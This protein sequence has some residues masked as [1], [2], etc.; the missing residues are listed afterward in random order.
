V[1]SIKRKVWLGLSLMILGYSISMIFGFFYGQY[2]Q[3]RLTGV[4]E[5][6]FPAVRQSQSAL[7]AFNQGMKA[8][9][10]GVIGSDLTAVDSG[11]ENMMEA[12]EALRKVM[13][14]MG[15]VPQKKAEIEQLLA[16]L[17]KFHASAQVVYT[18]MADL[19]LAAPAIE[20]EKPLDEQGAELMQQ[21][22]ELKGQLTQLMDSL[23]DT[24]K[25]KL[26]SL[27]MLTRRQ[28]YANLLIFVV[29]VGT[30]TLFVSLIINRS[31]LRPINQAMVFSNAIAGGDFTVRMQVRDHDELG[32]LLTGLSRMAEELNTLVGRVQHTG[33]QVSSSVAELSATAKEQEVTIIHQL[34]STSEVVKSVEE[35]AGIATELVLTMRQVAVMSQETADFA[36][37]GQIDL[38][39]ME[40]AMNRMGTASQA[41]SGRL[42]AINEKAENITAI[43]TTINKVADQTNLLSLNAAIEAEKAG[44]F[45]RGFTVVAREIRRLADQTAIA[46][47]DI[48]QMVK[49]MQS[50]VAA[51]VMEMDKFI[52][53]VRHSASDVEAISVQ[54]TKIIERV[55]SLSPHFTDVNTAM[56]HQ[57][58]QAHGVNQAIMQLSEEMQQTTASFKESFDALEH[59]NDAAFDLQQGV[60]QFK[61]TS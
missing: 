1:L 37:S 36:S 18:K 32:K 54:L 16:L 44:E 56:M 40:D 25:A 21:S 46:T 43:V 41:I 34:H 58:E 28:W 47:L 20:G 45:G 53:E 10:D 6:L 51:G 57:S 49:E 42:E 48:A 8:Y 12:Q 59:L 3:S 22:E 9:G 23:A 14:L 4:S 27:S 61:V 31:V 17:T 50:A 60:S 33:M 5:H 26:Q 30:T 38:S 11:H 29:V 35:I 13:D 39:R 15:F 24:L 52:A 2:T 19:S 55:R 7:S